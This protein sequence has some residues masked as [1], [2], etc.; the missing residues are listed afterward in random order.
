MTVGSPLKLYDSLDRRIEDFIPTGSVVGMYTCGPTVYGYPHIGNMR[1]YVFADTLRR[2]LRWKGYEA[3]QIVNITDVGHLVAEADEGQDKLERAASKE[4]RSVYEIAAHYTDAF[5]ADSKL[6]NILPAD[7]YPR[8][9]AYVDEMIKFAEVLQGKGFAYEIPTGLY[10]DTTKSPGYGQLGMIDVASQLEGARVAEVSGRR[11][12]TDFAL[13][14]AEAPG[15]RRAMRWNSPWGWGAPGWHLECSVLSMRYLGEHFDL[16]TGGVDHR[17]LHHVNEIAQSEAFLGDGKRW[18]RHWVHNEFLQLNSA[19]MSKSEGGVIRVA[20]LMDQGIHP[21]GY[22]LFLLGGHY[23]MQMD[24]SLSALESARATLRRLVGR[25]VSL[26]PFKPVDNLLQA[27]QAAGE[28]T[29]ALQYLDRVDAAISADLNTPQVLAQM[30]DAL[31]NAELTESGRQVVLSACEALLGLQ[32]DRIDPGDLEQHQ[33]LAPEQVAT[34]ERLIAERTEARA[35]RDWATADALR[36]QLGELG[37]DITDTAD[38]TTWAPSGT[39]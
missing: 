21:M 7:E 36:S 2:A 26:R 34:I 13:W 3:K 11:N 6:L 28:D 37:V 39:A 29:V 38:G 35:R 17:E 12:K 5:L 18:V 23:R 9:T 19:K 30:Q 16:H 20:D 8:A 31:R 33:A 22:R 27:R 1:A 4:Q 32:L 25:V 24:F 10:F 15:Q 14:R